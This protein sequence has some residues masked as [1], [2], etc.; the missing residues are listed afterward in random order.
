MHFLVIVAVVALVLIAYVVFGGDN[1]IPPE[2]LEERDEGDVIFERIV[3][4][5][6]KTGALQL[7]ANFDGHDYLFV[8]HHEVKLPSALPPAFAAWGR[9]H[10]DP[11]AMLGRTVVE[12]GVQSLDEQWVFASSDPDRLRELLA[13]ARIQEALLDLGRQIPSDMLK[14]VSFTL[15]TLPQESERDE[16]PFGD[17]LVQD[18]M[19]RFAVALSSVLGPYHDHEITD[20]Y[21]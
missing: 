20:F 18:A 12:S 6:R 7:A 15:S 11:P 9:D 3:N 21:G 5:R 4:R 19:V 17:A 2:L 13:D 8:I 1:T 14:I 16:Y 10:P